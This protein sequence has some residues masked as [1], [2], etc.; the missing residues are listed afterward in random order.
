M[1]YSAETAKIL[2]GTNGQIFALSPLPN[3]ANINHIS[4]SFYLVAVTSPKG[5]CILIIL[6]FYYRYSFNT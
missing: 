4:D 6:N 5:V 2:G 1:Y 3:A